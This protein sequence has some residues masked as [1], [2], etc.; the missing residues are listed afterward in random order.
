MMRF[1]P[2]LEKTI[3]R[4]IKKATETRNEYVTL[5]HVLLAGIED[6]EIS[7]IIE[8]CSGNIELLKKK[9]EKFISENLERIEEVQLDGAPL[10]AKVKAP[11]GEFKPVLTVAFHRVIQR[12]VLQ[13][14]SAGKSI[15][16]S[17][18]LLSPAS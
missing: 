12:A 7:D 2:E 5:E 1:T 15:V 16:T 14:E 8:G 3:S 9:L 11:A 17:G 13:V 10:P 6:P 4:S 18:N